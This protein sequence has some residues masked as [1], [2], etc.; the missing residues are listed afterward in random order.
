MTTELAFPAVEKALGRSNATRADV[1]GRTV[2]PAGPAKAAVSSSG[3]RCPASAVRVQALGMEN[4]VGVVMA[5]A[6]SNRRNAMCVA[7]A[8]VRVGVT[9]NAG[10]V[11]GRERSQSP[12]GNAADPA[13]TA[14]PEPKFDIQ[15]ADCKGKMSM[16]WLLVFGIIVCA[17]YRTAKQGRFSTATVALGIAFGI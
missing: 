16:F 13:G 1:P 5:A 8:A 9:W 12:A 15:V 6:T 10:G 11:T 7:G 17:V 2:T 3:Q 4:P 14:F